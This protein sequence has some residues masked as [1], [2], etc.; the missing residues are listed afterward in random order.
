M[1]WESCCTNYLLSPRG[2]LCEGKAPFVYTRS[3]VFIRKICTLQLVYSLVYLT[4]IYG[5][6]S[7]TSLGD[8]SRL[9]PTWRSPSSSS[10]PFPFAQT[11]K[12]V[13]WQMIPCSKNAHY[14]TSLFRPIQIQAIHWHP[15]IKTQLEHRHKGT[16]F[17]ITWN[18][19][20]N[21]LLR[22]CL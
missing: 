15:L 6:G 5:A 19:Q 14:Q 22:K 17:F 2:Y 21:F 11:Q 8:D 3:G 1:L 13:L 18:K 7:D 16:S 12:G 20:N 9:S 10:W 4:S